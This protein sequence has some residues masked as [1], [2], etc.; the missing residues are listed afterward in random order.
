MCIWSEGRRHRTSDFS[1]EMRPKPRRVKGGGKAESAAPTLKPGTPHG[2]RR[3][4]RVCFLMGK[5]GGH[6]STVETR[7]DLHQEP[8]TNE[9]LNRCG[10]LGAYGRQGNPGRRRLHS[11]CPAFRS[12]APSML[13]PAGATSAK[14]QGT[15]A[16]KG[17]LLS[18]CPVEFLG[19]FIAWK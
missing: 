12:L 3:M 15:C 1:V 9:A 11:S 10:L 17:S 19:K 16:F 14:L 8:H 2:C 18:E 4:Y 5:W 13:C 6:V 7:D